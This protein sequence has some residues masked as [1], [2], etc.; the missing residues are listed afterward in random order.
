DVSPT[1]WRCPEKWLMILILKQCSKPPLRSPH[2]LS[3]WTCITC[4]LPT[5]L[6]ISHLYSHEFTFDS[7][8]NCQS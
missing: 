8:V 7:S 3:Y 6:T 1:S 2:D 4:I 5:C